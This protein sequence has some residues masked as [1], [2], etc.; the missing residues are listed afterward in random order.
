[1][2]FLDKIDNYFYS[3]KPTEVWMMVVLAAVLIGYLIYSILSPIAADYREAQV[4]INKDLTK[5]INDSRNFLRSITVNGDKNY[6]V[7]ALDKKIVNK[8]RELNS[9]RN[10]MSKLSGAMHKLSNILYTKDNWSKFLHN[11][12]IK[13]KDDN[14]KVYSIDNMVYDQ[15]ATT[16]GKVL[17]VNIKCQGDYGE[18]LSFMNDLEQTNLVANISGVRLK[19]SN[20]API[21]DVNLSVWGIQP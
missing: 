18:I 21:A 14:L 9:Y 20:K 3:K 10:K 2:D 17:D 11:I 4:S 8:T 16:F 5:K 15:N 6:K 19:A 7:K 1:M 12:A 13:A